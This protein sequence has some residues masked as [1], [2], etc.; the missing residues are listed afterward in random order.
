M[1]R[2]ESRRR[3]FNGGGTGPRRLFPNKGKGA[4]RP[5]VTLVQDHSRGGTTP[6]DR[7]TTKESADRVGVKRPVGERVSGFFSPNL[8]RDVKLILTHQFNPGSLYELAR[9]EWLANDL[10][11]AKTFLALVRLLEHE[12]HMA[13]EGLI[14]THVFGPHSTFV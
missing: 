13:A 7:L 6:P 8:I 10:H 11:E 1:K 3:R 9:A 2:S 4:A 12:H 14:V 5:I